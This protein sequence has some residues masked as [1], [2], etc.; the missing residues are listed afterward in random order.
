MR[1]SATYPTVSLVPIHVL[2][3]VYRNEVGR[4]CAAATW[5]WQNIYVNC[6]NPPKNLQ[7]EK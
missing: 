4:H 2:R 5:K 7:N 6:V 3:D 1:T